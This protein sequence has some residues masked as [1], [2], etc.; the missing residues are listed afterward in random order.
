MSDNATVSTLRQELAGAEGIARIEILTKLASLLSKV[1]PA[2]ARAYADEAVT[3]ARELTSSATSSDSGRQAGQSALAEALLV[4]GLCILANSISPDSISVLEEAAALSEKL[5]NW[6]QTTEALI[7]LGT[8]HLKFE[9]FERAVAANERACAIGEREKLPPKLLGDIYAKMAMAYLSAKRNEDSQAALTRAEELTTQTED[10]NSKCS[11]LHVSA[12]IKTSLGDFAAAI[13]V[14]EELLTLVR[15]T[16]QT[17]NQLAVLNNLSIALEARNEHQRALQVTEELVALARTAGFE[18][19]EAKGLRS[20]GGFSMQYGNYDRAIYSLEAALL[21]A[22][23]ASEKHFLLEVLAELGNAHVESG[24]PERGKPYLIE[25]A[26]LFFTLERKHSHIAALKILVEHT[27]DNCP[28]EKLLA[29]LEPEKQMSYNAG[30]SVPMRVHVFRGILLE[31]MGRIDEARAELKTAL[32]MSREFESACL[33]TDAL[34]KMGL[35]ESR[36]G[37]IEL[38]GQYL[39]NA[40]FAVVECH[41][42]MT[43]RSIHDALVRHFEKLGDFEQALAQQKEMAGLDRKVLFSRIADRV[44][45]LTSQDNIRELQRKIDKADRQIE[46]E[47]QTIAEARQTNADRASAKAAQEMALRSIRKLL[48]EEKNR[49]LSEVQ[50]L[51]RLDMAKLTTDEAPA[52]RALQPEHQSGDDRQFALDLARRFPSLTKRELKVAELLR[53]KKSTKEI[54]V[55]LHISTRAAETYRFRIRRKLQL[56]RGDDLAQ[57]LA[58]IAERVD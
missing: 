43:K 57:I 25:A 36:A 16:G 2:P 40:L 15:R 27:P 45:R 23:R 7:V 5:G 53:L 6:S 50:D 52:A 31:R 41:D 26:D 3:L 35:L 4:Q 18:W 58:D 9:E 44:E 8:A 29:F 55:I 12:A 54:A 42:W 34:L 51:I 48:H 39:R 56:A 37:R 32:E 38:A 17:H 30:M 22:R 49:S 20:I 46:A 47:L 21:L 10:L 11:V 19:V 24:N 33:Q 1:E 14:Y 28:P 13:D